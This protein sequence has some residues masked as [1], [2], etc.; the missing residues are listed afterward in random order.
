MPRPVDVWLA[1]GVRRPLQALAAMPKRRS[2]I[3]RICADGGPGS[4]LLLESA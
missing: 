1:A 2:A 4:V 3:L